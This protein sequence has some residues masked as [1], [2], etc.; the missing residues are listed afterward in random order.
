MADSLRPTAIQL[1]EVNATPEPAAIP[2]DEEALIA[3]ARRGDLDAFNVLVGRYQNAVYNLCLRTLGAPQ[4]AEDA[5]QEAPQRLPAPRYVPRR[6]LPVV[7]VSDRLNACYDELRRRKARPSVS[8]D[9]PRGEDDRGYDVPSGAPTMEEHAERTELH[10]AIEAALTR[11]P[12]DQRLA[13]V[14]VDVQG[15]DYAEV[16][17]IMRCSLGTVK[18][19]INRGRVRL[20]AYLREREELLPERFR[21]TGEDQ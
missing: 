1:R 10:G 12:D 3:D 13:I 21:Q 7:A 15:F 5:A 17:A 19:R 2:P 6:L 9:E 4:P 20:R 8:L 11:L 14:L 16:A 18:S